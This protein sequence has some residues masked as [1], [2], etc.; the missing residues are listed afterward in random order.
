MNRIKIN[1]ETLIRKRFQTYDYISERMAGFYLAGKLATAE[2]TE[3]DTLA[4]E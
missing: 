2:Y 1:M 4:R 3:L